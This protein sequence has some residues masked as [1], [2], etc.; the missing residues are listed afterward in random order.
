MKRV[1]HF[2]FLTD[3]LTTGKGKCVKQTFCLLFICTT[4]A[5]KQNNLDVTEI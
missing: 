2:L 4:I 5:H 3:A 1:K